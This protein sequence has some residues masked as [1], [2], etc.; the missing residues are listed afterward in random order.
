MSDIKCRPTKFQAGDFVLTP[1]REVKIVARV[2][3]QQVKGKIIS[4]VYRMV[5][6]KEY[7][8]EWQLQRS[9]DPYGDSWRGRK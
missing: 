4:V 1:K 7:W 2:G 5:G 6:N 3:V 8:H 9:R